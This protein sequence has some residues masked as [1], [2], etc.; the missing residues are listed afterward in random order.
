MTSFDSAVRRRDL[1]CSLALLV[2]VALFFSDV[3]ASGANFYFRDLYRYH[4]PMK[5]VVRA[6]IEAGDMP[7]WNRF[8]S[9]GQPMAANPAYEIF[10]P[11]QWLIFVGAFPFGFALHIVAHIALAAIGMFALLRR[12]SLHVEAALFGALSFGL[13][14]Y[15]LSST[16]NLP[17][18]FVWCW[19]PCV[20]ASLLRWLHEKSARTFALVAIAAGIQALVGEPV[21][22][23]ESWALLA[24]AAYLHERNVGRSVARIAAL[25]VAAFLIAAV[26]LIPMVDHA[27]DSARARGFAF[28]TVVD[29]STTPAR[30]AELFDPDAVLRLGGMTQNTPPARSNDAPKPGVPAPR[31]R[32]IPSLYCGLPIVL[33]ALAGWLAR[34]R[35]GL[36][37]AVIFACSLL[38]AVGDRTP[39]FRWAYAIGVRSIRY[40]EKFIAAGL[41]AL[42][43]FA[44]C[45]AARFLDGDALVRRA[46]MVAAFVMVPATALLA[47][48]ARHDHNSSAPAW[49]AV[50]LAAVW[51]LFILLRATAERRKATLIWNMLALLLLVGD[52]ALR[53]R[54]AAPRAPAALFDEPEIV[55]AFDADR[56]AYSIFD[57]RSWQLSIESAKWAAVPSLSIQRNSLLP[58]QPNAFGLRGALEFDYD[59][60][61]LLPTHD[62]IDAMKA[63]GA[64][65]VRNWSDPFMSMANVRY[66][67]DDAN[68]DATMKAAHGDPAR[69]LPIRVRRL[70]N[71]PPRYYFARRLVQMRTPAELVSE[72]LRDS[73]TYGNAYVPIAPFATAPARVL[74]LR[75]TSST[76]D[77]DVACD[78]PAFLVMTVTRH[79]YWSATIDGAAA[80]IVPANLAFQGVIVPAG[81][82]HVAMRYRN[83]LVLAGGAMSLLSLAACAVTFLLPRR[84]NDADPVDSPIEEGDSA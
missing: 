72:L 41:F 13:G 76:A 78:G 30:M 37:A 83:P 19:T 55:A 32:Y 40:P 5:A 27:R 15:M 24:V 65:G 18:M 56:P 79:K 17:M 44:A 9:A 42:I 52:L 16:T 21:A 47:L 3:L 63:Y 68:F 29:Y 71:P 51:L 20:A 39:L 70:D 82:H 49:S 62:L 10:Y 14:A 66:V 34:L 8:I 58:F 77:L 67:I 6:T 35:G 69:A 74:A 28:A 12:I 73:Q 81:A 80:P 2:L 23:L 57:R 25:A 11:P 53:A 38:L 48:I 75:E 1:W 45:A 54:A 61:D 7:W 60:T 84:R 26:Q 31:T 22:L 43:V 64:R 36:I 46:A 50:A 33:F 59:E 4:F